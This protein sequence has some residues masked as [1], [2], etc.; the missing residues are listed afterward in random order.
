VKGK[1][2]GIRQKGKTTTNELRMLNGKDLVVIDC[3]PLCKVKQFQNKL[4]ANK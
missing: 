4:P 2:E 1:A 3:E